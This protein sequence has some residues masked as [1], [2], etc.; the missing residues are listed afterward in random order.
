MS[1][2]CSIPRLWRGGTLK[3]TSQSG[4]LLP[5]SDLWQDSSHSF[6]HSANHL[7]LPTAQDKNP[8]VILSFPFLHSPHSVSQWI[9]NTRIQSHHHVLTWRPYSPWSLADWLLHP[10]LHNLCSPRCSEVMLLLSYRSFGGFSDCRREA[11]VVRILYQAAFGLPPLKPSL[12][13]R[14]Q[15]SPCQWELL[16]GPYV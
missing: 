7:A 11:Q 12:P 14:L 6:P 4:S 9:P 13:L 8:G 2:W 1:V 3:W 16:W 15:R 5:T 10:T